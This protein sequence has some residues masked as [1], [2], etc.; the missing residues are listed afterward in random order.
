MA[1][2]LQGLAFVNQDFRAWKRWQQALEANRWMADD[3]E[4]NALSFQM[5]YMRQFLQPLLHRLDRMLMGPSVEGRVPFLENDLMKFAFNLEMRQKSSGSTTKH[6]LKQVALRYLPPEIVNRKK[7]GFTVPFASY[8]T[9]YPDLLNDGFVADW[10]G[11]TNKEIQSWCNGNVDL[12]YRLLS[13]EVWGRI[14]VH[15]TP[16]TDIAIEM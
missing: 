5:F 10:A 4:K 3:L 2:P 1:S 7:R 13:I 9:K 16:W 8:I 15:K 12:I 14:F 6:L 11:L